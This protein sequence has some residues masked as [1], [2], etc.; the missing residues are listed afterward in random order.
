[1]P[2]YNRNHPSPRYHELIRKHRELHLESESIEKE[3]FSG[4]KMI[5]DVDRIKW[6]IDNTNTQSILDYGSG[7]GHLYFKKN[8]LIE[9]NKPPITLTE[10]WNNIKITCFDPCYPPYSSLPVDKFDGVIC[11]DVLEH[12][13]KEDIPWII[14]ELFEYASLFVY[15]NVACEQAAKTFADGENVHSTV[16]PSE[17]WNTIFEGVAKNH[18]HIQWELI[19]TKHGNKQKNVWFP[20]KTYGNIN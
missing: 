18:P 10:F 11:I 15:A 6:I 5:G 8:I 16:Q 12:C 1:M 13:P 2:S 3:I 20:D 9:K 14:N 7:K 4:N 17:W 19:T